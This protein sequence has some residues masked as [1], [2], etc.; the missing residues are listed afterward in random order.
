MGIMMGIM[1]VLMVAGFL[2]RGH[3]DR[4]MGGYEK[5]T[6]KEV[7]VVKEQAEGSPGAGPEK[8]GD[9]KLEET[10]DEQYRNESAKPE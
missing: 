7:T 1:M 3:H 10:S 6:Q 8:A 9:L 2:G 4:M 5:E